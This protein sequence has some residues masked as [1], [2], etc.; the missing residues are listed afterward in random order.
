MGGNVGNLLLQISL[1]KELT[2]FFFQSVGDII[3]HFQ[4]QFNCGIFLF[5]FC[6]FFCSFFV[7]FFFFTIKRLCR[8][9]KLWR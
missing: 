1:E 7:L 6:V 4:R 2:V 3:S 8:H 5:V 9:H